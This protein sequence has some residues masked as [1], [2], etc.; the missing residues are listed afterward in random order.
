MALS[1]QEVEQYHR[2]GYVCPVPV[3]SAPEAHGLRRQLEAVEARQGGKLEAAQRS[4]AFLL[5]KWLDDLI[6]DPRVLDPIEQLIGPDILCWSTI[7]WIKDA[8][9]KSFVGWH[10][11]N[12]YWGLSSRNVITAWFAISDAS[13]DAGCMKVMPRT[14]LG[15]TLRHEDTYHQDNMLTR[16][17]VIPGLD[18]SRAVVMPL[19][20]GEM[21]L[22]NYCLAH[23]SGPNVSPDRRIGVSMH[24][25]PPATKQVVGAWDCAALVRGEDRFGNFALT[26]KPVGDFD[27]EAV[28][29]H[30]QAA[31][32]MREVLYAGA[33]R[34]LGRL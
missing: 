32:A 1:T 15:E 9:S 19:R 20:A 34:K 8:G 21:S 7:F 22:H 30:A 14:H 28:A 3:M 6:R 25:M 17:Q 23:G 31:K 4:R 33:E 5:F 18:E 12:T 11:D 26:P 10:Q 16:G 13:V 29:F 27:P 2:D 24:F